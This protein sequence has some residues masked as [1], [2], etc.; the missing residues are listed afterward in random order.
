MKPNKNI[1]DEKN[2]K[3]TVEAHKKLKIYCAEH[4]MNLKDFCTKLVLE[5][6]E[7]QEKKNQKKKKQGNLDKSRP[8]PNQ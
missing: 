7:E 6:I 2:V 8:G 4:E 3:I 5:Y 1:E